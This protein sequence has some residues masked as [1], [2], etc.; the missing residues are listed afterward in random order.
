M[1]APHE[2]GF[3]LE[4]AAVAPSL[5]IFVAPTSRTHR[6]R[7]CA[8]IDG[9]NLYRS[10]LNAYGPSHRTPRYDVLALAEK[11][12]ELEELGEVT[13]VMF[14]TG[15]HSTKKP[16]LREFWVKKLAAMG[17]Q[18]GANGARVHP[19]ARQL[20]YTREERVR[21]D[22]TVEEWFAGHEKGIDVKMALDMVRM[23]RTG[24]HDV[25]VVFSQDADF[26]E[27][28]TEARLIA[29]EHG[30]SLDMVCAFPVAPPGGARTRGI[31]GT[32][33]VG[34]P[35]DV[36]ELALDRRNYWPP[37]EPTRP[38]VAVTAPDLVTTTF[39]PESA[40]APE[41]MI[42]A[43]SAHAGFTP[44][45][46]AIGPLRAPT[47]LPALPLPSPLSPAPAPPQPP[48]YGRSSERAASPVAP[49]PTYVRRPRSM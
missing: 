12:A 29:A 17:R 44:P 24:Q 36:Y 32:R 19:Y 26:S 11:V 40:T 4:E 6:P 46:L 7:V 1:N 33:H 13:D 23:A 3:P 37:R 2:D 35:K 34:I 8:F 14:Y 31:P 5:P 28:I 20:Q 16:A 42:H 22:G 45:E 47:N 43:P 21:E 48:L 38:S 30:R 10:A 41:P 49:R 18:V 25:C 39:T 9:Q 15:I 27:A